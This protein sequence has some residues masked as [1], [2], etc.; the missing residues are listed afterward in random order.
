MVYKL[1]NGENTYE[2]K[3]FNVM[4]YVKGEETDNVSDS[5]KA[6][7]AKIDV[8][9]FSILVPYGST[10]NILNLINAAENFDAR[11]SNDFKM[12][13]KVYENSTDATEKSSYSSTGYIRSLTEEVQGTDRLITAQFVSSNTALA[14]L[15]ING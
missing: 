4:S 7:G 2:L 13:V 12:S 6:S 5:P 9:D 1:I 14:N 11:N 10:V 8:V 15:A 3:D